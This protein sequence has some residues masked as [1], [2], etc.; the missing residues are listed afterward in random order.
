[1]ELD[2]ED[3]F[4]TEMVLCHDNKLLVCAHT[5]GLVTIINTESMTVISTS[6]PFEEKYGA[7]DNLSNIKRIEPEV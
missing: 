4:V 7:I 3:K 2:I 5:N 6:V 1:M